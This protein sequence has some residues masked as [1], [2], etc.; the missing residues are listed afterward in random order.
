MQ[1]NLINSKIKQVTQLLKDSKY[2]VAL[3]GAGISVSSGIPPFRG[4][5]GLWSKYN[6]IVLELNYFYEHPKESWEVIREIF[7]DFFGKA[8]PNEAHYGLAHFQ[9]TG[10]LKSI[11]TQNI[12][13]LHQEAGSSHVIEF[14]G[15]A[16]RL[17]CTK[18]GM[19]YKPS[20]VDLDHLPPLCDI[21]GGLLKPDFIF[22]GEGIPGDAYEKSVEA[23]KNAE[24]VLIVG[25][26]GEV[27]PASQLPLIAKA[28]GAKI[29]E[30]NTV[31]S[32]YTYETTDIFMREK[33]ELIIPK[34]ANE[35]LNK[36]E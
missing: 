13:N 15:S 24:L 9:E 10:F 25:T 21:D 35:F 23:M 18:C 33:A 16:Q 12:D 32:A 31:P 26:T 27:A 4:E 3:T 17:V 14:H 36:L 34:L 28:S 20:S 5:N 8:K 30:I 2:T 6:P 19:V 29:V 22:F 7:Y 1:V 11:I